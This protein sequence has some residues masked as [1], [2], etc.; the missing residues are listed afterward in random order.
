MILRDEMIEES[1]IVILGQIV[2]NRSA[3]HKRTSI[4]KPSCRPQCFRPYQYPTACDILNAVSLLDSQRFVNNA[5]CDVR[6]FDCLSCVLELDVCRKCLIRDF[7]KTD[8]QGD[9]CE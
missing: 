7:L 3:R 2:A 4:R 5:I 1:A 8:V 6:V 9:L